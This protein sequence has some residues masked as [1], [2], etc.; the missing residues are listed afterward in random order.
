MAIYN[1]ACVLCRRTATV[2]DGPHLQARR[3]ACSELGGCTT[4][5]IGAEAERYIQKRAARLKDLL[6]LVS[7]A[8]R[9]KTTEKAGPLIISSETHLIAIAGEQDALE[10]PKTVSGSGGLRDRR[11]VQHEKRNPQAPSQEKAG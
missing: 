6:A 9:R 1:D 8:A 7:R 11:W 4:F 2:T 10:Q 5:D 3:F